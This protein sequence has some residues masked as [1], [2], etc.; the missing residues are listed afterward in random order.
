MTDVFHFVRLDIFSLKKGSKAIFGSLVAPIL[1]FFPLGLED[2]FRISFLFL[3]AMLMIVFGSL[4]VFAVEEKSDMRRLYSLLPLNRTNIVIGRYLSGIFLGAFF[5]LIVSAVSFP[6]VS[7]FNLLPSRLFWEILWETLGVFLFLTA[8]EYPLFVHVG[9]SKAQTGA[10]ILA[11]LVF[12]L[13]IFLVKTHREAYM[14]MLL[15]HGGLLL[16]ALGI[17]AIAVSIGISIRIYRKKE[18]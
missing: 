4:Q 9:F 2:F 16:L 10:T 5:L 12:Y 14:Q 7:A 13:D 18:L 11:V 17:A 6:F 15:S 8:V 3:F 1:L